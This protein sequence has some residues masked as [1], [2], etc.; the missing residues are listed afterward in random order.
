MGFEGI[1]F[2]SYLMQLCLIYMA[3][4][5]A[6]QAALIL[7]AYREQSEE[8]IAESQLELSK[9]FHC[10]ICRHHEASNGMRTNAERPEMLQR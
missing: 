8:R 10:F 9:A 2:S 1:V 6:P 7:T 3:P 4:Q 5:A